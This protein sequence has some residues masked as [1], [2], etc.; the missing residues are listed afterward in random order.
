MLKVERGGCPPF[1]LSSRARDAGIVWRPRFP[2]RPRFFLVGQ[3]G[4]GRGCV[5]P[6]RRPAR[7]A[8]HAADRRRD[9]D[10]DRVLGI[11][12]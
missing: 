7:A 12:K 4:A 10:H 9:R 8:D 1:P 3:D 11:V 2:R 5:L 6:T